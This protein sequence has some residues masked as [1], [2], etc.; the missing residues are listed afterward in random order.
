[1]NRKDDKDIP[2]RFYVTKYAKI[3]LIKKG[4]YYRYDG[5]YTIQG[6]EDFVNEG[7]T[8]TRARLVQGRSDM[9][10]SIKRFVVDVYRFFLGTLDKTPLKGFPIGLKV[11]LV[12]LIPTILVVILLRYICSYFCDSDEKNVK[13]PKEKPKEKTKEE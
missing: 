3:V 11:F 6:F 2:D 7:Y 5:P 10:T 4:K 12:S 13:K 9:L 1:M 8:T